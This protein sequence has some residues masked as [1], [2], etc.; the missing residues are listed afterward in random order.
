[1]RHPSHVP[2]WCRQLE[3]THALATWTRTC[4]GSPSLPKSRLAS[5]YVAACPALARDA[6]SRPKPAPACTFVPHWLSPR[7]ARVF[8]QQT[9][10]YHL[11]PSSGPAWPADPST[12]ARRIQ[13]AHSS[14]S[15]VGNCFSATIDSIFGSLLNKPQR[16]TKRPSADAYV[17]GGVCEAS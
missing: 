12:T 4:R 6:I 8:A 1:M 11:A 2:A 13:P 7:R 3:A 16:G 14:S 5:A 17:A 15:S 9:V 10:E